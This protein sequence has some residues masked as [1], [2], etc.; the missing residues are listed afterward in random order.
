MM[1]RSGKR[2]AVPRSATVQVPAPSV[3]WLELT[4]EVLKIA[5]RA[6]RLQDVPNA[7]AVCK[8]IERI[9]LDEFVRSV[10]E[11]SYDEDERQGVLE[12]KFCSNLAAWPVHVLAAL[13]KA[14]GVDINRKTA[15]HTLLHRASFNGR[16]RAVEALLVEGATTDIFNEGGCLPL[17]LAAAKGHSEAVGSLA[18]ASAEVNAADY[19]GWTPLHH[20]ACKGHTEAVTALLRA[21]AAIA[22]TTNNSRATPL[23]I[24]AQN[25]HTQTVES[26][27][28]AG[29][30]TKATDNSGA[31]P[32]NRA[33][34]K[35]RIE[36][37]TLLLRVSVVDTADNSG[38]TALN[39]AAFKGH[40]ETV[41]L[42]LRV[43][44]VD[45]NGRTPLHVAAGNG[46]RQAVI[47]LLGAGADPSA[48]DNAGDTPFN[49][50]SQNGHVQIAVTL[51]AAGEAARNAQT[52][53]TTWSANW[54]EHD[55]LPH[56]KQRVLPMCSVCQEFTAGADGMCSVCSR[57][58]T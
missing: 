17:T 33:A 3:Q 48:A 22:A 11:N 35:G 34:S 23:H 57:N 29:A 15:G 45:S 19:G 21:G 9:P 30:P 37:V 8:T 53:S 10:F 7:R 28:D 27:L 55:Q 44:V 20:A 39:R 4:T 58:S 6:L 52:W 32:L 24:A 49:I 43:S 5:L 51:E 16:T 50:A 36:T 12:A 56:I 26:L 1:R 46:H 13:L 25:G 14:R 38:A 2:T 47:S 31:T 41:K 42:L 54:F 18:R 40:I